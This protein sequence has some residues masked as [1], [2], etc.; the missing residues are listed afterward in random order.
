[1]TQSTALARQMLINTRSTKRKSNLPTGGSRQKRHKKNGQIETQTP[2][3]RRGRPGPR[4]R[5]SNR[6]RKHIRSPSNSCAASS[7]V[8]DLGS[9]D[10]D[11][12]NDVARANAP[13]SSYDSESHAGD[14]TYAPQADTGSCSYEENNYGTSATSV[15]VGSSSIDSIRPAPS[16]PS[17][18]S[19][20]D[21][22]P[23]SAL[24]SNTSIRSRATRQKRDAMAEGSRQKRRKNNAEARTQSR[25]ASQ[26][27]AHARCDRSPSVRLRTHSPDNF[28]PTIASPYG[29]NGSDGNSSYVA[30]A[31]P[32]PSSSGVE[33]HGGGRS[34]V[35]SDYGRDPSYATQADPD[36]LRFDGQSH[37]RTATPAAS[38]FGTS[39]DKGKRRA[40]RS[41][42]PLSSK[43]TRRSSPQSQHPFR[44]HQAR[45]RHA[46]QQSRNSRKSYVVRPSYHEDPQP[47]HPDPHFAGG[48]HP[49]HHS[50][51]A[52]ISPTNS[53]MARNRKRSQ[54]DFSSP[55]PETPRR[56]LRRT[57]ESD[58]STESLQ[59]S[60]RAK[61]RHREKRVPANSLNIP[62]FYDDVIVDPAM[63]AD[64]REQPV[65]T[66]LLSSDVEGWRNSVTPAD[67]FITSPGRSRQH[68]HHCSGHSH[69]T[70]RS[71]CECG[72]G[73][74]FNTQVLHQLEMIAAG[75]NRSW[76][77]PS[78]P[79]Q[80]SREHSLLARVRKHIKTLLGQCSE[81]NV[82]PPPATAREKDR[83]NREVVNDEVSDDDDLSSPDAS[84]LHRDVDP[85]FPYGISGPGHR[86]ASKE[87][88]AIMW[89][90]MRRA[91]V[92]S[93]RPDF[94]QAVRQPDNLFLWD[95][96]HSIFIKLVKAGEYDDI[97]LDTCSEEKIHQA[98]LSHAKTLR[99]QFREGGWDPERVNH[100]AV[101]KRRRARTKHLCD[102]RSKLVMKHP[103]LT[104][105]LPI[106]TKC[107]SDAE[108]DNE[109]EE[110][111]SEE[112][113]SSGKRLIIQDLPWRHPRVTRIFEMI[114]QMIDSERKSGSKSYG[115]YVVNKR[116]RPNTPHV[117]SKPCPPGL[118]ADCIN[119]DWMRSQR[120]STINT[121]KI[122]PGPPL[123]PLKQILKSFL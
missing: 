51:N 86:E 54:P 52:P 6:A 84:P 62:S 108:T 38:L 36:H 24:M 3:A 4:N 97:D 40:D 10:S 1:M 60:R 79:S 30:L 5:R 111:S 45:R 78:R 94:N 23:S 37:G 110:S 77:P 81:T 7:S 25:R 18:V 114:D 80:Q 102:I 53:I 48:T 67:R 74:G 98:I 15:P 19:S 33:R 16:L 42:S 104:A 116:V 70:C 61:Y 32:P 76:L 72:S 119:G 85:A 87:T 113:N 66:R 68:Q 69:N 92:R 2:R 88:L 112:E 101:V 21:F 107:T 50:V 96:A 11:H 46:Q 44:R 115:K 31:N 91:R 93:F 12:T 75:V 120:L 90:A 109:M 89:R 13:P 47:S 63:A 20:S 122:Q 43:R 59:R 105:L 39:R 100:R 64:I 41:P 73:C 27:G 26:G 103:G 117:S 118:P 58:F 9:H 106:I 95:L 14:A 22:A 34:F 17:Q 8:Y 55:S 29:I 82:L 57:A 28:C 49:M 56:R 71:A 35:P 123:H 65:S 121:L 99:R 83:W